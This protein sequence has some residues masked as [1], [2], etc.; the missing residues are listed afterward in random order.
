ML[1]HELMMLVAAPLLVMGRPLAA[2]AW[3]VPRDRRARLATLTHAPVLRIPWQAAT[4]M[5]GATLLQLAA[6][7]LWHV[8]ALFD[9]AAGHRG[10]HALQHAT[11]LASAL[12]YWWAVRA[13]ASD[14][15]RGAAIASLFATTMATGALGALLTFSTVPWYASALAP[16]GGGTPL[17]DQQ[18]GGLI[19]WV[20]GGVA[21]LVAALAHARLLL[22]GGAE[23]SLAMGPPR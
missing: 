2:F 18:L 1:Q 5:L 19:M 4:G 9:L 3:A 10:W 22:R 17:D 6:L 11:F 8:P 15:A 12:A 23:P 14:A 16:P 21:Y 7:A 13:G 20:P